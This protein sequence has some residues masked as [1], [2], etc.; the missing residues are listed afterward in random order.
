MFRFA[1]PKKK[2]PG[3]AV[4][5]PPVAT[6]PPPKTPLPLWLYPMAVRPLGTKP[7]T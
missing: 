2:K 3:V 7:S 5:K 1:A 6:K 4:A